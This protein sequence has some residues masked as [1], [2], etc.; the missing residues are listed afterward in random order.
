LVVP[1]TAASSSGVPPTAS[2]SN[3]VTQEIPNRPLVSLGS[4]C[5]FQTAPPSVVA[6]TP[7]P[8]GPKLAVWSLTTQQS[9]A[10]GH[11]MPFGE[12]DRGSFFPMLNSEAS[13]PPETA[14]S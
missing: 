7:P 14:R 5:R 4:L 8:P 12:M 2:Q 10:L 1:T 6:R 9:S 3:V 13:A 11:E